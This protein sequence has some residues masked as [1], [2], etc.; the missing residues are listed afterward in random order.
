MDTPYHLEG[1]L[2]DPLSLEGLGKK[3]GGEMKFSDPMEWIQMDEIARL[4]RTVLVGPESALAQ[5]PFHPNLRAE[6]A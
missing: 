1:H 4:G 3:L 6:A 5:L 2:L